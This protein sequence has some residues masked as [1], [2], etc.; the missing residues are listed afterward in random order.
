[1]KA[2]TVRIEIDIETV[3]NTD[4]E[5]SNIE[6]KF[7]R[8]GDAADKAGRSVQEA[9]N[10]VS[11]FDQAA[12][13][14]QRS[15][16]QWMKEKYEV[17]L[18]ARD[19]VSPVLSVIGRGIKGVAGRTWSVTM[20]AVDFVTTPVRGILNLLK[21]PVFQVGAVLGVSIGFGSAVNTF[22]DFEAAMSQVQAVSGATSYEL[23]RLTEKAQQ[24]GA[25]TKFTAT[26][27][28]EAFNYMAMAG[29]KTGDMLDGIEGILHLAAASGEDLATTSDI[30]TDALTAFGLQASDSG[31]FADVLA[32]ASS[33]A[34]TN[35]S[36][37]GESFKYVAPVAGA[38]SYNVEDVSLALGL[39]ANASVKGSMAGTSL[40]TALT[41][42][43][44]PTKKMAAA[45][46]KY[47]ISLMDQ[48]G[49]M[50]TLQGV[51]DNLRGSLGNLS[52]A[53]Q[54][55]AA[56]TI[57]GKEAMAGMLSVINASEADYNKLS[58]AVNNADGAAQGMSDTMLDNLQGSITLLQSAVDGVQNSFGQR[59][60]PYISGMAEGL[61]DMMPY[62]ETGI[63]EFMDFVDQK[64]DRI[65][66]KLQEISLTDEWQDASFLGK[67]KIA[68]D[69]VIAQPFSEWW[70]SA[71]KQMLSEK[72]GDIG[73]IIGSGISAGLLMLLGID[74]SDSVN[75]GAS[76][77]K[78]FAS[79]FVEGFD[80]DM[81]SSK[82]WDGLGK[83]L[84]NASKLLPGGESPDLSSLMS[85]AL[86]AKIASP[87]WSLGGGALGMG[88]ALF[89]APA[90]GGPSVMANLLGSAGAGTGLLGFGANTAI[91]LGAG[92]LAG[93][94]SLSSGAL[95]AL[96]LGSVAGGIVG[97]V[98]LASGGA[99]IYKAI[100]SEDV[101]ESLAYA[102][103]GASKIGG[104]GAGA[105][106]GALVGSAFGGIGAIPGALIGGGIGGIM[107]WAKGDSITKE[108]ERS[109]A[110][111]Q[112]AAEKARKVLVA[113]GFSLDEVK[114]ETKALN[115]AVADTSV[116]AEQLGFMF[117]E[118]V[119]SKLID[120]FGGLHLSLAEIKDTAAQIVFDK[121]ADG[122]Q[123]FADVS[124]ASSNALAKFQGQVR[125]LDKLNWK[126]GLGL[127]LD[128]GDIEGY[129]SAIDEMASQAKDYVESRHYEATVA[130]ELLLGEEGAGHLSGN[131]NTMYENMQ[132]QLGDIGGQ[133]TAKMDVALE[134]GV[135]TLDEKAEIDNLQQQIT[136]IT[137]KVTQA[138]EAAK[139]DALKIRYGGSA[140]DAESFASLQQELASNVESM[141]ESYDSALEVSLTNLQLQLAEGAI[142]QGQFDKMLAE[143]TE[144]YNAQID[145]L[146]VRVGSFQ[147]ETIAEAFGSELDG[148]LPELEGT[149]SE[150][151]QEAMSRALA[152]EPDAASWTASDIAK[153][154]GLEGLSGETQTAVSALL[155]QTAETIPEKV[156]EAF[157]GVDYSTAATAMQ[158]GLSRGITAAGAI[159]GLDLSPISQ[160]IT[161]GL[162]SALGAADYAATGAAVASGV[163]SA[164][165][166]A[167]M[168]PINAAINTVY[169]NTGAQIN[170]TFASPFSTS[171]DVHVRLAWKL[172]NPTANINVDGGGSTTVTANISGHAAGGYV[173]GKQLSWLAEE[174]YGEFVIPT[175]PSR[176]A[177]A[178]D[179][180]EQ[181]GAML[182][183]SAHAAGGY[184][185]GSIPDNIPMGYGLASGDDWDAPVGH[186]DAA[187]GSYGGEQAQV[188]SP[189]ATDNTG[190]TGSP[191]VQVNVSL[192]PEFVI[193][194]GDGQSGG[195]IVQEI[196]KQIKEM[197]DEL[198]EEI[199]SALEEVFGNMPVKEA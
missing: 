76:I 92:N 161:S 144:G 119:N 120:A 98:T 53:E 90:G 70:D 86:L 163:G 160:G 23:D 103:S 35:V 82:L 185:G 4:P 22:K 48:H 174:G 25:T 169:S 32:Q 122:I 183:V 80:F 20:K 2:E 180:Y 170:S 145:S 37:L 62:I 153:W 58:K 91:R 186:D 147:L 40:K 69:E 21:N 151:L 184:V 187:G 199:A 196:R 130:L 133:L 141:T 71:G 7:A 89:G 195:D 176:R 132:A 27:S 52:E 152:V 84:S 178:L 87:V 55:A 143:V 50:K 81:V 197:A 113:T 19:R 61:T 181:A 60:S 194:A 39:M 17:L 156:T 128:E 54:T 29:W 14:T 171:A 41:N 108:Y 42:M 124:Q 140:L 123:K 172:M 28:A 192:A 118:S 94:A 3:D 148:I 162:G 51:M 112:E 1:M 154:F 49:N 93:G 6:K 109:Q 99:D 66:A 74:V 135:I 139:F 65:Q 45:M 104:V 105:A 5:V 188:Y 157:A 78:A 111:A 102:K 68:W 121:Q 125:N 38:M 79:G 165:S 46:D 77:G 16:N 198:G 26:E 44:A 110:E 85:A 83:Q 164:V 137:N 36:M 64:I 34:N 138:Q 15:L 115:D 30:V 56:S 8:M 97:G 191:P 114:F 167:D 31:H 59:L 175:N 126:A 9:G 107:G 127:E 117:Q 67:V 47:G 96:G 190:G 177:R 101:D 168:G 100:R 193:Q 24:M 131:M 33:N 158:E 136:E 149:T 142:D 106:A 189:A 10:R 182:G 57:F 95:S 179:L 159:M 150:R 116:S 75:E 12:E 13:K 134:D 88:R 129:K 63:N 43:A 73:L 72:A 155:Q 11:K 146:Q 166:A 173:R 18:D